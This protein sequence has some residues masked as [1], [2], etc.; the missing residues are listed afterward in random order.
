MKWLPNLYILE[1]MALGIKTCQDYYPDVIIFVFDLFSFK[2]KRIE[3][4]V[5]MHRDEVI[6]NS[7]ESRMGPWF[8]C[9][10]KSAILGLGLGHKW[11]EHRYSSAEYTN[12]L[13]LHC[14]NRLI[15]NIT[16][17]L[18]IKYHAYFKK[19]RQSLVFP[20]PFRW[21]LEQLSD[22]DVKNTTNK[23]WFM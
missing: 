15:G 14:F 5:K 21:Y 4:F 12:T 10:S 16:G 13:I 20:I 22:Q 11:E 1:E 17:P 6:Y 18:K 2:I 8:F 23:M 7:L 3:L 9:S 19:K